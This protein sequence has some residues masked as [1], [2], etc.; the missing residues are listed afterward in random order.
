MEQVDGGNNIRWKNLLSYNHVSVI[1]PDKDRIWFGTYFYGFGGGGFRTTL[2]RVPLI[3]KNSIR[4]MT[5]RRRSSAWHWMVNPF[6]LDLK[7]DSAFLTRRE[8]AGKIFTP[9]GGP[10]WEFCERSSG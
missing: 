5:A 4:I 6:G 7:K 2:R 3:G 10:I 8:K 1:L 9:S